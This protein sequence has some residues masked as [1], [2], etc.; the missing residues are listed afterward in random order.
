[1]S[2]GR[3]H[4][5]PEEGRPLLERNQGAIADNATGKGSAVVKRAVRR[6]NC[7]AAFSAVVIAAGY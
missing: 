2:A 6:G 3:R 4:A 1:M 7:R 5:E